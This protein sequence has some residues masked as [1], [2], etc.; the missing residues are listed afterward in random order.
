M[1]IKKEK[2]RPGMALNLIKV[3]S[4]R[5]IKILTFIGVILLLVM[6]TVGTLFGL[7][8]TGFFGTLD[9]PSPKAV[10]ILESLGIKTDSG[11]IGPVVR[12]IGQAIRGVKHENFRLPLNFVRAQFSNPDKIYIDIAFENYQKLEY[13]RDKSLELGALIAED[14]DF[15][16][17]TITYEGKPIRVD[18]RLKGDWLDHLKTDKWS[19]RVE[20]KGNNTLFG[21]KTFSLQNPGSRNYVDEFIFQNA[22]K[23]EGIIGLRTKFLEVVLNGENKGIYEM[24]EHFDKRLIEN[25]EFREGPII[26]FNE[27]PFWDATFFGP[28]MPRDKRMTEFYFTADIDSFNTNKIIENQV[29]YKQYLTAKNLL[30]SFRQGTLNTSNVFDIEKLA[31]FYALSEVMGAE[32]GLIYGNLRFYYNP[33]TSRL[34]PIGFDGEPGKP[35]PELAFIDPTYIKPFNVQLFSDMA[36]FEKYVQEL[37]RMSDQDYLDKIFSGMEEDIKRNVNIIRKDEPFYYFSDDIYYTHQEDIR[38]YLSP[39]KVVQAYFSKKT[40]EVIVL[41]LVNMQPLPVRIESI[42]LNG[43]VELPA[44]EE[45]ILPPKML[46]EMGKYEKL[47]FLIPDIEWSDPFTKDILVNYRILGTSKTRNETVFQWS[48]LD[49]NFAE[50]D[51]IRQPSNI[52]EFKFVSVNKNT[53]S[54]F[55]KQGY[56]VIGRNLIIPEGFIVFC[57]PGTVLDLRNN[58]L[59]LSYS[60]IYCV[61]TEKNPVKIISSD[62]TGQGLAVLNADDNN[63]T[64]G[65]KSYFENVVFDNLAAPSQNGW[66]LT[67][68]LTFYESY[69]EFNNV[70]IINGRAEDGLNIIRST[71]AINN[72]HFN[73]SFSDC[74]DGDFVNGRIEE[75][76]FENCGNDGVD[77]SGSEIEIYGLTVLNVGD[78][79]LSAGEQ[80]AVNAK[81][82]LI[83]NSHIGIASKDKSLVSIGEV[84]IKDS[85]YGLAVYEKKPE[86]GP[87]SIHITGPLKLAGVNIPSIIEEGSSVMGN[88]KIIHGSQKNVYSTLYPVN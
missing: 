75:T 26:S 72:S 88:E 52:G 3:I 70:H 16:P 69:V 38:K 46:N 86:F 82:I 34:E 10:N 54:I 76:I 49:E 37:E 50:K 18:L 24:E 15:V 19:F 87:A 61:G 60:T 30:E 59:I 48:Y 6:F 2:Y 11:Q 29:L 25:N 31:K 39:P 9:N 23:N 7:F 84:V 85:K 68:S 55:I 63:N 14:D 74:F 47:E 1:E 51:F 21:L 80:S 58:S 57:D 79:A 64:I 62:G 17:A 78:K 71:F 13:K 27:D 56:W 45:Y 41:E 35:T 83:H 73:N 5:R 42:L 77:F 44:K 53:N 66:E 8:I 4:S 65:S 22:L 43:S 32:H 40:D 33:V 12:F 20:V 67:G 28:E 81:N 36:F